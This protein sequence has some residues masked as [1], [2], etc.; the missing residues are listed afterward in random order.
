MAARRIVYPVDTSDRMANLVLGS[1]LG[2]LL[3]LLGLVALLDSEEEPP[4]EQAATTEVPTDDGVPSADPS[5]TAAADDADVRE[6]DAVVVVPPV[7][8]GQTA[9]GEGTV[10]SPDPVPPLRP[11]AERD[12]PTATPTRTPPATAPEADDGVAGDDS[13][14]EVVGDPD[15]EVVDRPGDGADDDPD[16][17]VVV[18]ASGI[19]DP[20]R[21]PA[22]VISDRPIDVRTVLADL[23]GD[24]VPERVWA[25]IVRNAV[26]V[27]VERYDR[28]GRWREVAETT[29]AVADDLVG[30]WVQDLTGD[31]R[32]EIHTKQWVGAS[33]ESVTLWSFSD[34]RIQPMT[35]SGGCWDG[36]NT[37]GVVGA[38]VHR[39]QVLAICE[40]DPLPPQ[41]WSTAVYRWQDGRWTFQ[42]R[43]GAYR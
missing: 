33:G 14:D 36:Q 40:E 19:D 23:D 28:D 7:A 9:P 22:L 34:D 20:D 42:Q 37:F 41:L 11:R 35:A 27:R 18:P 25:A 30:L 31:G 4:S 24:R 32:P 6:T 17:P 43:V 3:A 29:G 13:D 12:Q 26:E 15:G 16:M 1:L 10:R 2:G 38:L 21:V 8:D 5:P 39:G